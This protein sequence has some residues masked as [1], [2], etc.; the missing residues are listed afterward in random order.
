M[1]SDRDLY[2][3]RIVLFIPIVSLIRLDWLDSSGK[4]RYSWMTIII[5]SSQSLVLGSWRKKTKIRRAKCFRECITSGAICL[6]LKNIQRCCWCDWWCCVSNWLNWDLN[7]WKEMSF[8]GKNFDQL[9]IR[10]LNISAISSAEPITPECNA[11]GI[12]DYQ[13]NNFS[14]PLV[15][16]ANL[17]SK[18][19]WEGLKAHKTIRA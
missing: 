14:G 4:S 17:T 11:A 15:G 9:G 18:N 3:W 12:A 16:A 10:V 13:R 19:I 2:R 8:E 1:R 5:S 6:L 7:S